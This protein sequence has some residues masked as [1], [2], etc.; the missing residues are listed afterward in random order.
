MPFLDD[1]EPVEDRL[2]RFWDE[3]PNGRVFTELVN[4]HAGDSVIMV[5]SVYKDK[6]DLYPDA[7]G[8][9][10]ETPG[11]NPVNKTS[12]IENCE[13]SAIGRALANMGY[14]PKG[15]RPS[16]EEIQK[17]LRGRAQKPAAKYKPRASHI[18]L[19]D[20]AKDASVDDALRHRIIAYLTRGAHTSVKTL[21]DDQ[22]D[23]ITAQLAYFQTHRAAAMLELE[24]WEADQ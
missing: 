9:A 6:A 19:L 13:T 17:P 1:Y 15:A 10:Q 7:T 12:W 3:H 20:A 5:A 22:A 11:S 24:K 21:T 8:Y 14:A 16:R 4:G 23:K 18:R 2:R